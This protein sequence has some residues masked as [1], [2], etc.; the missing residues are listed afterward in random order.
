LSTEP[1]P[2]VAESDRWATPSQAASVAGVERWR[3]TVAADRGELR[4]NGKVRTER[5]ID[6][7]SVFDWMRKRAEQPETVETD[8]QVAA[9]GRRAA[10]K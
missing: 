3:I 9:A 8:A 10:G 5:R 1:I 6:K 2:D 7:I 4:T